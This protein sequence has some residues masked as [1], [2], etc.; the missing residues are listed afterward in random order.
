MEEEFVTC[1]ILVV[2]WV[3]K[4]VDYVLCPIQSEVFDCFAG[5]FVKDVV[6]YPIKGGF[7]F[8]CF[9]NFFGHKTVL[10]DDLSVLKEFG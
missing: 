9:L 2:L 8:L 10:D 6:D 4:A 1:G 5:S 3:K 7:C